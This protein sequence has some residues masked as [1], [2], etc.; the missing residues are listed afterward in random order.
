MIVCLNCGSEI[1]SAQ[2]GCNKKIGCKGAG[3]RRTVS[4]CSKNGSHII[5]EDAK[6]N[7]LCPECG[8]R[9]KIVVTG[10]IKPD[11]LVAKAKV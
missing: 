8:A 1:V 9:L 10:H 3:M 5:T 4:L 2:I 11:P 6:K 7:G